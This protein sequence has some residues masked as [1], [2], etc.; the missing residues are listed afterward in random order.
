M[1]IFYPQGA[2][3]VPRSHSMLAARIDRRWASCR[4]PR[5]IG[6]VAGSGAAKPSQ[7][8]RK[9]TGSLRCARN[10][11]L[12][13][14]SWEEVLRLRYVEARVGDCQRV[15]RDGRGRCQLDALKIIDDKRAPTAV[16]HRAPSGPN[17]MKPVL[18]PEP[19]ATA[20]N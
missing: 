3:N 18:L 14:D 10:D 19:N 13:M 16:F 5:V 7:K 17:T 9:Y 15:R 8:R 11:A 2:D 4:A 6:S 20:T 12:R 1:C